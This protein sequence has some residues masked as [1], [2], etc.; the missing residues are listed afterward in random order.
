[1]HQ[2]NHDI[3]FKSIKQMSNKLGV[4]DSWLY[5]RTRKGEIPCYRLGKYIKFIEEEVMDWIKH[6]QEED[7]I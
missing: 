3:S 4:P 7:K 1:M 6:L 2:N 5:A